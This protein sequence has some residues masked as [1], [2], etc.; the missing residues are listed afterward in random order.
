[1]AVAN[2]FV[3]SIN[4][5]GSAIVKINYTVAK[6]RDYKVGK[7]IFD[8]EKKYLL[9]KGVKVLVY[10]EV[11]NKNHEGFLKKMGFVKEAFGSKESYLKRLA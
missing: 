1:M 11:F 5:D 2:I 4:A 7:F 6:Y 8:H 9:S 3:A 10:E